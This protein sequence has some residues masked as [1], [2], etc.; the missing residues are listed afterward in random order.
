MNMPVCAW[1]QLVKRQIKSLKSQLNNLDIEV[2]K[3]STWTE[4]GRA[5]Y[6]LL[7]TY[8]IPA[9]SLEGKL[10]QVGVPKELIS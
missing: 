8:G 6:K 3:V 7:R 5:A 2:E 1:Y 4:K 9:V 10:V